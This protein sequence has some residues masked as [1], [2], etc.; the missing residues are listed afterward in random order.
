MAAVTSYGRMMIMKSASIIETMYKDHSI[1]DH[2][3]CI[4]LGLDYEGEPDADPRPRKLG[5]VD[6]DACITFGIDPDKEPDP[7]L[8]TAVGVVDREACIA[9]GID[10]DK[11]PAKVPDPRIRKLGVVDRDACI[12]L[13]LDPDKEPMP[14]PRPRKL[15]SARII[16][17]DTDSVVIDFGDIGLQDM[18]RYA[19]A[20]ATACTAAMEKPNSLAFESVKIHSLFLCP[21]RYGS[22][23]ILAGDIKKGWKIQD[24]IT[25][26]KAKLSFKVKDVY[27]SQ[28]ERR[29]QTHFTNRDWKASEETMLSLDRKRKKR[30]L[31]K[32]CYITMSMLPSYSSNRSLKI[33]KWIALT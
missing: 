28:Q 7:R 11:E 25:N 33:F 4:A 18:V 24:C 2:E 20:A 16:Y 22:L 8:R 1:V 21:K 14:D 26:G 5:D 17:G 3:A 15:Y 32:S 10:P 27:A 12:A 31:N 29:F 23:E 13:G 30:F 9:R 6:R 19:T